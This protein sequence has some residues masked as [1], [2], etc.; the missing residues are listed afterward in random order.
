MA[1]YPAVSVS[2]VEGPRDNLFMELEGGALDIAIV[3]GEVGLHAGIVLPVWAGQIMVAMPK[4][5]RLA[6]SEAIYWTDLKSERFLLSCC[7][8]GPEIENLLMAKLAAPGER[9]LVDSHKVSRE[10]ILSMVGIGRG[11]TLLCAAGTGAAHAGV[12]YREVREGTGPS[13]IGHSACWRSD[14]VDPALLRFVDV[15]KTRYPPAGAS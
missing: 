2:A 10:T 14:N 12:V 6:S 3:S 11:V 13:L 4:E 7:D 15:L 5:H 1:R 9:P 8:P